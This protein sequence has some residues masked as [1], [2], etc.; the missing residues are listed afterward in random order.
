LADQDDVDGSTIEGEQTGERIIRRGRPQQQQSKR[1]SKKGSFDSPLGQ[2]QLQRGLYSLFK[3]ATIPLRSDAEYEES[4]FSEASKDLIDLVN[5]L[6]PLRFF[7]NF[8]APLSAV[9]V[10]KDKVQRLLQQRK[11]KQQPE[12]MYPPS[13]QPTSMYS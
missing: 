3:A 1:A 7:F 10:L 6:I 2:Q 4:E 8:I 5:R 9:I 13:D 12:P 11:Q